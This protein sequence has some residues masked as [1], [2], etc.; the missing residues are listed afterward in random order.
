MSEKLSLQH[1][2]EAEYV[3]DDNTAHEMALRSDEHRTQAA[4]ARTALE[5][6]KRMYMHGK[7]MS[8]RDM[9][10]NADVSRVYD[11]VGMGEVVPAAG[12]AGEAHFIKV[13]QAVESA[14]VT[15][16]EMEYGDH[17]DFN[18]SSVVDAED[19]EAQYLRLARLAASEN[20]GKLDG[21]NLVAA[22]FHDAKAETL[23]TQRT[24]E[25][26]NTVRVEP[27]PA[28]VKTKSKLWGRRK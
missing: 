27:Q 15:P 28:Q 1:P 12:S 26:Q 11:T 8:L 23:E 20:Q 6:I 5:H 21:S 7:D 10:N 17:M 14:Y 25:P 19:I 22:G 3:Q 18:G 24:Q 9:S 2:N 16:L 4:V 13:S